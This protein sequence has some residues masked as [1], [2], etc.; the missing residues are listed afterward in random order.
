MNRFVEPPRA[1]ELGGL[2]VAGVLLDIGNQARI[3]DRLAIRLRIKAAIQVEIRA[4]EI[5]TRQFGD[6]LQGLQA[7]PFQGVDV[8]GNFV[9]P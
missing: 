2:A 8:F 4:L 7:Q 3:E 6:P 9:P 1:P 5:Q